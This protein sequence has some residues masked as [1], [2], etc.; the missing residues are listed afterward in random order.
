MKDKVVDRLLDISTELLLL[1][2]IVP[3]AE[4]WKKADCDLYVKVKVPESVNVFFSKTVEF[5]NKQAEEN[6][7]GEEING[8][9][10]LQLALE[11][12][13]SWLV[14]VGVQRWASR[15]LSYWA[16]KYGVTVTGSDIAR[17][18]LEEWNRLLQEEISRKEEK[19][20]DD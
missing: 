17:F 20:K 15:I 19:I 4:A 5:L 6:N 18:L 10:V 2:L 8:Q 16:S 12:L 1:N 11:N 9:L 13:F 3:G 7:L 14:A